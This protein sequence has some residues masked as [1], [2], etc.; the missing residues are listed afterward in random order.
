MTDDELKTLVD[1]F[2]GISSMPPNSRPPT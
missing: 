2:F 1:R